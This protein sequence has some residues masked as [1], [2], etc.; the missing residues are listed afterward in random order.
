VVDGIWLGG[1]LVLHAPP[2]TN[3]IGTVTNTGLIDLNG[4]LVT[5]L[6][7][8][9]PGQVRLSASATIGFLGPPAQLHFSPGSAVSWTSGALLSIT[10]WNSSQAGNSHIFFGANSSGLSASQLAQI[11]FVNPGGFPPGVYSAR[12]TATG[13]LAPV[14][15]PILQSFGSSSGLVLNWPGGYQLLSATNV[16]GPYAPVSGATSPRTNVFAKP[17]EFFKLQ[18]L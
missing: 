2:P 10:N 11:R 5:G 9:W 13:E 17:R 18:G 16:T 8:A 15:H 14:G 3:S 4:N 12:L 7:D 6:P 1:S